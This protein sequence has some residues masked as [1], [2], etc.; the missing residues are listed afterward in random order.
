MFKGNT[1]TN[2]SGEVVARK[3][4]STKMFEVDDARV[5]SSGTAM[6][7]IY[8]AHANQL[9]ALGNQSRLSS[10]NTKPT[11]YSPSAKAAYSNEVQSLDTKLNVALKNA[12]RERQA[13][14][15]SNSIINAKKDANPDMDPSDLKKE[16][17]RALT[18][19]RARVGAK[20]EQIKIT[21]REW[22]AI[23]AGALSNNKV[24]SI[25]N[26]TDLDALKQRAMPRQS[27]A[28]SANKLALARARLASG[29]T[30]AEVA[31]SLGISTTAL[32]KALS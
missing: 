9:K 31:E 6:E 19:A 20:K 25:L 22:D 2:R 7:E 1:Y 26:N 29:Y 15:L 8:A 10:L 5:L 18:E 23:Q 21:D 24:S 4:R 16:K 27:A 30:Q 32:V 12:P 14:L 28:I 3:E 13:V 11:P 17:G